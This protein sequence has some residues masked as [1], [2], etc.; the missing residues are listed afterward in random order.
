MDDCLVPWLNPL[1]GVSDSLDHHLGIDLISML[2]KI[3]AW[4]RLAPVYQ[5]GFC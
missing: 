4:T 3:V 1:Q 5:L 2:A